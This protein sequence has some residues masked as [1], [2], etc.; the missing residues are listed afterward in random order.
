MNKIRASLL[1]SAALLLAG[2]G[3]VFGSDASQD[4]DPLAVVS[5][6]GYDRLIADIQLVGSLAGR[7]GLAAGL[8]GRWQS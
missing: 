5:V 1:S 2:L 8:Q 6:A 7:P 4:R 3:V